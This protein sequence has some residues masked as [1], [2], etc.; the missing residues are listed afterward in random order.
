MAS[1]FGHEQ[2][3]ADN[4]EESNCAISGSENT[5]HILVEVT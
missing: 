2:I 3:A 4:E 1:K 5:K